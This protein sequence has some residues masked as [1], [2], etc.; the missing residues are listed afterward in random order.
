MK[1]KFLVSSVCVAAMF[2]PHPSLAATNITE[3]VTLAEDAD[4]R[5]RGTVTISEGV[6]LDLGGHALY[7]RGLAGG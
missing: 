6:K 7:V 3:N 1:S 4:W 2:A 5:D